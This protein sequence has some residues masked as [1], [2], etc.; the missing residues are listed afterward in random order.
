[1]ENTQKIS[2]FG[3]SMVTPGDA[4]YAAAV[5]V[6]AA[7]ARAGYAVM[8]GG[9]GGIMEASSR[10]ASEAGGHVIG[11]TTEQLD[12]LREV[13][14]NAW[15]AEHRVYPRLA[16][17]L[18]HLV[19]EANGYVVMPGGVGTLGELTLAWEYMRVREIPLRPL[20]CYGDLWR[21][22]LAPF[23]DDRYVPPSHQAMVT[24]VNTPDQIVQALQP[25]D[26]S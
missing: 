1:M 18:N 20:L 9:Y 10:G 3:S 21:T 24:F 26:G 23:L 2:V 22:V 16:D 7:L 5:A 12:E 11:V 17:R 8:S 25:G 19:R 4:D 15:V 14:V 6:G 13:R